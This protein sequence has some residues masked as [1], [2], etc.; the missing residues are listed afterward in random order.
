MTRE[1]VFFYIRS[2]PGNGRKVVGKHI[3]YHLDLRAKKLYI[4][5]SLTGHFDIFQT[6]QFPEDTYPAD[7]LFLWQRISSTNVN[8]EGFVYQYE[9]CDFEND[10]EPRNVLWVLLWTNVCLS[11][12]FFRHLVAINVTLA[13]ESLVNAWSVH[14]VRDI[15]TCIVWNL[16]CKST[17]LVFII[18]TLYFSSFF[19]NPFFWTQ[20]GRED[21]KVFFLQYFASMVVSV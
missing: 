9:H 3:D 2:S 4:N 10:W 7:R 16:P 8:C 19:F 21:V 18:F 1:L 6:R 20:K 12:V 5:T 17:C 14:F 13:K 15:I 11:F